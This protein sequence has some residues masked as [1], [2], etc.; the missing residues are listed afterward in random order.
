VVPK[1]GT[2][3]LD[4]GGKACVAQNPQDIGGV[5]ID[6]LLSRDCSGAVC[7]SR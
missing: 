6:P 4:V 5:F 1:E 3:H 7:T 2:G